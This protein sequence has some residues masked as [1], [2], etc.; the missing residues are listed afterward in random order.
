MQILDEGTT[1]EA[2][3]RYCLKFLTPLQG[4]L[5]TLLH[6]HSLADTLVLQTAR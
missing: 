2:H 3:I 5:E 4:F 6:S 1:K